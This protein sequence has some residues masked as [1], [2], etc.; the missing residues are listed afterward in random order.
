MC[1]V[2]MARADGTATDAIDSERRDDGRN[3]PYETDKWR[4]TQNIA[5][6]MVEYN[7]D[8]ILIITRC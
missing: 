4:N 3:A 2:L 1:S 5:P 8:D 7:R 6:L